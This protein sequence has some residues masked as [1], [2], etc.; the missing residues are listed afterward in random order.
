VALLVL[1]AGG[2]TVGIDGGQQAAGGRGQLPRV[3]M[4]GL[5][6]QELLHRPGELE[7]QPGRDRGQR[8]PDHPGV[9]GRDRPGALR[10]R[11]LGEQRLQRCPGH[12]AARPQIP[13]RPQP[14]TRLRGRDPGQ[15]GEQVRGAGAAV[16]PGDPALVQL[17]HHPV[18]DRHQPAP[19]GFHRG[20]QPGHLGRGQQRQISLEQPVDRGLQRVHRGGEPDLLHTVNLEPGYDNFRRSQPTFP[21]KFTGNSAAIPPAILRATLSA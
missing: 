4:P 8:C 10:G 14:R 15:R 19:F 9:L 5:V 16:L 17:G 11:N 12:V 6:D 13:R 21:K 20:E 18:V 1:L 7:G 2:R 3:Q